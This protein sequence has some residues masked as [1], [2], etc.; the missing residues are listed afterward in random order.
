VVLN[1]TAVGGS[2][3][4]HL[5]TWASGHPKPGTSSVNFAAGQ[6]RPNLVIVPV[7]SGGMI[8]IFNNAGTVDVVADVE[9]WFD[10]GG[11]AGASRFE[12]F[13]PVRLLDTRVGLGGPMAKVAGGT[14]IE[15]AV[16][17][18]GGVP[19][20]GV[21]AVVL[22]VT[23]ANPTATSNLTVWPAGQARPLASNLNFV[24]GQTVPNLV[25]AT[26]GAGGAIAIFNNS[27]QTDVIADVVG[28][29]G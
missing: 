22:N 8:S 24:P 9:G 23:V 27:G 19:K 3:A 15:L 25:I 26:V 29:F 10:A 7:G 13:S 17:N 14:S 1:L 12:A 4:S 20:S 28:W 5:S 21:S 6:S 2:E 18:G 11:D 16:T